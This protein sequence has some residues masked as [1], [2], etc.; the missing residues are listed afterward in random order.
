MNT[1]IAQIVYRIKCNGISDGQQEEQW[2]LICANDI[3]GATA[4]A[5]FIARAE[6]TTFTDRKGRDITW[7]FVAV[8][9]IQP[10]EL[11]HGSILF[12][13]IKDDEPITITAW[14]E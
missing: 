14:Q 12:S 10:A 8:K 13:V 3:D 7:E 4:E 1:Y 5:V 9:D 11:S 6:E 2:R